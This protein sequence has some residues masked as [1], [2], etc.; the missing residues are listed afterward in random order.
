MASRTGDP[1]ADLLL[2]ITEYG[3][4]CFNISGGDISGQSADALVRL[5][6]ARRTTKWNRHPAIYPT[7]A[8]LRRAAF[9]RA[10]GTK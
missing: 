7:T 2:A 4:V 8:G 5:G 3:G 6:Y 1:Q 9:L 10:Q